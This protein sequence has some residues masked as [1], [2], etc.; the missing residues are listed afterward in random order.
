MRQDALP[1]WPLNCAAN[2]LEAEDVSLL[3][4]FCDFFRVGSGWDGC[5]GGIPAHA[6]EASRA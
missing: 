5:T 2:Y 1:L 4:S 3:Y 6:S